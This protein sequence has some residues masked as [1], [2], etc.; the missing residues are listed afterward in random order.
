MS[1][2]V[3]SVL[4]VV[5]L[6]IHW[7]SHLMMFYFIFIFCFY[8]WLLFFTFY[9]TCVFILDWISVLAGVD[10]LSAVFFIFRFVR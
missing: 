7:L 8:I 9:A 1:I 4:V 2:I 10:L 6:Y 3:E 5:S